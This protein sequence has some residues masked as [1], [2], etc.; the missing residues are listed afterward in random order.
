VSRNI[1]PAAL[2]AVQAEVVLRTV[3]VELL[4]ASGPARFNGSPVSLFINGEEFLGVGGL[5]AI[6]AAEESAELQAYGLT[7]RLSGVPRD[8]VSLAL[9]DAYQ[10]RRATVWE[11]PLDR[12]TF[13]PLA[14]PVVVF[15]GRMDTMAVEMGP[16]ATVTVR[17]ENRLSDWERPRVRRFT[18]EDQQLAF[19][20]DR[21]FEFVASTA[22]KEIVWPAASF[23][24]RRD[25]R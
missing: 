10:G 6:S 17:L 21:G 13:Q 19:P 4:F 1:A 16:T 15:R 23:F 3:A 8:S 12:D 24:N 11:V 18:S 5:G 2:A 14:A 22:E 9:N 25:G 20:G 7:V